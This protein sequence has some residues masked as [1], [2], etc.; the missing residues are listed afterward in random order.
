MSKFRYPITF[1]QIFYETKQSNNPHFLYD[2]NPMKNDKKGK[3]F[4][5]KVFS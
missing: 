2:E 4:L 1:F 3:R 5:T